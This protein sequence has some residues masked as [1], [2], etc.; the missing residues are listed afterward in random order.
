MVK[1]QFKHKQQKKVCIYSAAWE[2]YQTI[3]RS[4][5][6]K[7]MIVQIHMQFNKFKIPKT[8]K[9]HKYIQL[10]NLNK[11]YKLN[12]S[13]TIRISNQLKQQIISPPLCNLNGSNI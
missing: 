10:S 2:F 13:N 1:K 4:R 3:R 9:K 12:Q 7:N 11:K 5:F 8:K 6:V